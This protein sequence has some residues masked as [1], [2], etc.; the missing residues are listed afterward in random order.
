MAKLAKLIPV[1][2][3]VF[4]PHCGEGQTEP[5]S[6]SFLW[7]LNI[8]ALGSFAPDRTCNDCGQSYTLRVPKRLG[9]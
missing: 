5:D 8:F 6:G 1:A 4:C 9:V 3:E 2:V 7:E